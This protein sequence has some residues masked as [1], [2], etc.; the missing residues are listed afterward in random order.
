MHRSKRLTTDNFDK[1]PQS[2]ENYLS[3]KLKLK[4]VIIFQL[5]LYEKHYNKIKRKS[6]YWIFFLAI[7]LLGHGAAFLFM[8]RDLYG[9]GGGEGIAIS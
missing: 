8:L 2:F 9:F 3:D 7:L 4:K 6:M 1:Q 5:E